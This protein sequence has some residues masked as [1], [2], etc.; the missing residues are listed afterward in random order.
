[1]TRSTT[2]LLCLLVTVALSA[3]GSGEEAPLP[4]PVPTPG[5]PL[6]P[7]SGERVPVTR[8]SPGNFEW[9]GGVTVATPG[10]GALTVYYS[11]DNP[12]RHVPSGAQSSLRRDTIA[13]V[14]RWPRVAPD[15]SRKCPPDVTPDAFM[16]ELQGIPAGRRTLGVYEAI[17]GQSS[18]ALAHVIQVDVPGEPKR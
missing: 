6:I 11:L 14:V 10:P 3:C 17:E 7:V 12:C 15:S 2:R 16:L 5:V 13:L 1:M 9:P 4:E 8:I 18:A